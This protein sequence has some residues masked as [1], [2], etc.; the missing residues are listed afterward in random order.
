MSLPNNLDGIQNKI[1]GLAGNIAASKALGAKEQQTLFRV[2]YAD[3]GRVSYVQ[4]D[5]RLDILTRGPLVST[6]NRGDIALGN[7]NGMYVFKQ[8]ITDS[9]DQAF[10]FSSTASLRIDKNGYLSTSADGTGYKV[11]SLPPRRR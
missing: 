6:G 5:T 11:D 3:N 4:Q 8:N 10:R 9:S 7:G 1:K 2:S